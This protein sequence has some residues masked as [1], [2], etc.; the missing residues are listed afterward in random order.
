MTFE[1][2]VHLLQEKRKKIIEELNN[3]KVECRTHFKREKE[4]VNKKS[5]TLGEMKQE[6]V[7]KLEELVEKKKYEE[8]YVKKQIYLSEFKSISELKINFAE[9]P[10]AYFSNSIKLE[11]LGCVKY[12]KSFKEIEQRYQEKNSQRKQQNSHKEETNFDLKSL[13]KEKH[14]MSN[15]FQDN[16]L[17]NKNYSTSP[18]KQGTSSTKNILKVEKQYSSS[19]SSKNTFY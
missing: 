14:K 4:K 18:H 9:I 10:F 12:Y 11:D 17:N 3:S 7:S 15:I 2:L 1:K 8:F 19:S 5:E 13:S 6:I 16:L